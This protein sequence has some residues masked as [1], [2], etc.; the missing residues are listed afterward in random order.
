M[1][2]KIR[3]CSL[4]MIV[5]AALSNA[6]VWAQSTVERLTLRRRVIRHGLKLRRY[7]RPML[8]KRCPN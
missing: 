4:I 8:R 3:L 7:S 1:N 6:T 5:L 2:M